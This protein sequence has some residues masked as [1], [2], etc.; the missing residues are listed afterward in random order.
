M[1][2][3][4]ARA[5]GRVNLIGEHTDYNGG[6]VLPTV[7]PQDTVVD[8]APRGD[9]RVQVRS[10]DVAPETSPEYELAHERRQQG[11]IDYVQGVT[12]ALR[13][14][15][16]ELRGFDL[17]IRSTVPVGKGLSSSASLEVAVARAL[18]L[19]FG[20]ALSDTEIANVSHRA[21]T[22]FVGVPVGLMDQM[23]CS[24]GR[25]GH[26][27]FFDTALMSVEHV[28]IPPHLELGVIDSGVAHAHASGEY[29]VR[30][31]QCQ[32]AAE[33]LGVPR[34]RDVQAEA[35]IA[36]ERLPPPLNRRARHVLTENGRVL[37]AVEALKRGDG[38]RLGTLFQ[39]SHASMR[40]HFE[41]S[42]PAIDRLTE[43]AVD[44]GALGARMT[45]GGF[46]GAIVLICNAG[47][48]SSVTHRT[49]DRYR[50][51]TSLDA[52]TLVP[53]ESAIRYDV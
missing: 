17:T 1:T 5:P 39:Q 53:R 26:A 52:R 9:R 18:N 8:L 29:R 6:F 51:D 34:L 43:I 11:W 27:L 21:E 35:S 10:L 22:E 25:T 46:G 31:Q 38:A 33:L 12:W 28:A 7:I 2:D 37:E 24:V 49:V 15:A 16:A 45:G 13:D 41:I 20:L 32:Q 44:C 14:R 42:T 50:A 23:V 3:V 40:D 48:A 19:A 4:R 47:T 30:R 36:I